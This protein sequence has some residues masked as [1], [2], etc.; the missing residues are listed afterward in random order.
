MQ[1]D[2][3]LVS[4]YAAGRCIFTGRSSMSRASWAVLLRLVISVA[5]ALVVSFSPACAQQPDF[6]EYRRAADYCRGDVARPMALSRDKRILCFD[7]TIEPRQDY[8]AV[9]FL[10]EGGLL[11]VRSPGGNMVSAIALAD[12]IR[13]RHATVVIHDYCLSACASFFL[14]ASEETFVLRNSIVA[15]SYSTE[16]PWCLSLTMAKDEG[17]KRLEIAPCSDAPREYQE[18]YKRFQD[19]IYSFYAER[20]ADP[21]AEWPP[22]S[23][24]VRRILLRKFEGTGSVPSSYWTWNPRHYAGAI[25]TKIVYEAYPQ[26]QDELDAIA[27][28][29]RLYHPVIYDP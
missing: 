11:V 15:W 18:G 25:K 2:I 14:F 24:F 28:R 17:P 20:G 27:A 26:T 29:I 16:P 8:S 5:V 4:F 22:Q 21:T 23:I 7:G 1:L 13:E 3:V 19:I 10:E 12:S 9:N 6:S